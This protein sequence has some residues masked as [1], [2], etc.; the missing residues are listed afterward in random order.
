MGH[1][2]KT[3]RHRIEQLPAAEIQ[4]RLNQAGMVVIS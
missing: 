1:L 3:E 4:R 2:T